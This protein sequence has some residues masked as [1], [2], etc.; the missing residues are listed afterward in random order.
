MYCMSHDYNISNQCNVETRAVITL[1]S[2]APRA[3]D[4]TKIQ[5]PIDESNNSNDT[6]KSN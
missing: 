3:H 4:E 1:N 2:K 6:S 5:E